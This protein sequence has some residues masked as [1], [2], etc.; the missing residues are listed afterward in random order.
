VDTVER[1]ET[2]PGADPA[3]HRA[4]RPYDAIVPPGANWRESFGDNLLCKW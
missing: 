4:V 1:G 3:T 2:P